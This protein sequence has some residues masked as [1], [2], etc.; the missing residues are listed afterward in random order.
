MGTE[1]SKSNY[2]RYNDQGRPITPPQ[3]E[4]DALMDPAAYKEFVASLE[5]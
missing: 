5:D 2:Y 4:L 3:A 1:D